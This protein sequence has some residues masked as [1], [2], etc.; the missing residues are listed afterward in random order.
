MPS[1]FEAIQ[2][3]LDRLFGEPSLRAAGA[4]SLVAIWEPPLDIAETDT[5]FVVTVDLADVRKDD[6]RVRLQAGVLT[7][8]GERRLRAEQKGKKYHRI[9]R[10]YGLFL[11]RFTVP[12]AVEGTAVR[13][14][15]ANGVLKVRLPKSAVSEPTTVDVRVA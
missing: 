12:S 15:Y 14:E 13:A 9:E 6:I 4:Q 11:R 7:I 10:Q 3:R 5:E 1:D 2:T 8:E